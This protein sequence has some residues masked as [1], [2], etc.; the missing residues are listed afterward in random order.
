MATA[1]LTIEIDLDVSG[2]YAGAEPDVGFSGGYEDL[3][4]DGAFGLK[5]VRFSRPTQFRRWDLLAGLDAKSRAIV[6]MNIQA[7]IGEDAIADALEAEAY[8]PMADRADDL[9]DQRRDDDLMARV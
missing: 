6:L 7:Q 9:R 1:T 2:E 4:V 3:S 8:D 5:H